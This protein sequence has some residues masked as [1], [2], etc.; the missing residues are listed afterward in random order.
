MALRVAIVFGGGGALGA[1]G[2]GVWKALAARLQG[3][4][5]IGAGGTSIGA[6]NAG[7]VAR[8]GPDVLGSASAME[9][10]WRKELVTPSLPFA[11]LPLHRVVQSWNGFLTG[12]FFGNRGL[13]HANYAHWNPVMGMNRFAHPL[14]DRSRMWA[15]IDSHLGSFRATSDKDTLLAAG[16]VDVMSGKLRM[17]DSTQEEVG[18]QHL[19]ASSAIPLLFEPVSIDDRLYWDG[20][21]TRQ[22]LLPQFLDAL[23]RSGRL[24]EQRPPGTETVLVTIDQMS[25]EASQA[26]TSGI[27]MA[28]RV[29]EL[30]TH[31]KM[32]VPPEQLTGIS[33]VVAIRRRPL[34]HDGV[35]GQMDWSPERIDELI[36]LGMTQ[37]EEAWDR[38]TPV[39]P[40]QKEADGQVLLPRFA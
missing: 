25:E 7:F 24:P 19:G 29:I 39:Q 16:A 12:L 6:L 18:V 34:S 32:S 21:I 27:E 9:A 1:F 35:S 15:L 5:I 33:R 28:Y 26:P 4:E 38:T 14:M 22:A 17:F 10:C 3:A 2:C 37:A 40:A 30:L 31:G 23:R 20:D 8:H 13:A 36:E 11:G